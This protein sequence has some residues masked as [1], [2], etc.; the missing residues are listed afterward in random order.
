MTSPERAVS[1]SPAKQRPWPIRVLTNPW[2]FQSIILVGLGVLAVTQLDFQEVA[3]SFLGADYGW[4]AVALALLVLGRA[5]HAYELRL[6]LRK[7]GTLPFAG[8]FGA[9]LIG[10]FVNAVTPARAGDLARLQIISNRY[11]LSRA[12]MI[13]GQ[14]AESAVDLVILLTL[15]MVSLALL[16]IDVGTPRL[17]WILAALVIVAFIAV[18]IVSRFLPPQMPAMRALR[19][20]PERV[21]KGLAGLWPSIHDGLE[22]LRDTY[23]LA[24]TVALNAFGWFLDMLVLWGFGLAFGLDIPWSGYLAASV[25]SSLVTMFPITPGNVGTYELVLVRV[26]GLYGVSA[27]AGFAFSVAVHVFSTLATFVL[28]LVAMLFMRVGFNEVFAFR[29]AAKTEEAST[30]E[31]VPRVPS[32]LP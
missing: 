20:L 7:V 25:A 18:T 23:L 3:D 9:F 1:A 15:G 29:R 28:G 19:W 14:G 22:A 6:T 32:A 27:D 16:Q 17:F 4:L 26:L 31:E 8:F 30:I 10:N 12:G 11:G 13:A 2:V 5:V 21:R 24:G